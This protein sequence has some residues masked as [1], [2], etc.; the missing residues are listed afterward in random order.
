MRK[1]WY[2][3]FRQNSTYIFIVDLPLLQ[4]EVAEAAGGE[5]EAAVRLSLQRLVDVLQGGLPRTS[6]QQVLGLTDEHVLLGDDLTTERSQNVEKGLTSVTSSEFESFLYR[7][8]MTDDDK[9]T[10]P[11]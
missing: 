6:P 3:E 10:F 9:T 2:K 4:G 7:A 5:E 1:I 11:C 8:Q